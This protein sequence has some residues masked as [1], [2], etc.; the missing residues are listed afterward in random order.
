MERDGALWQEESFDRIIRDAEHLWQC[1]QYIGRNPRFAGLPRDAYS[2]W[3]NPKWE[4]CGW[5]F[6]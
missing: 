5:R 6:E 1:L 2:L 4:A 3:V